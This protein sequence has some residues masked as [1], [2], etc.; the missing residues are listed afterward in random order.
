MPAEGPLRHRL[1]P[2]DRLIETLG[3]M[4]GA[5]A[6][7]A[8]LHLDRLQR[9]ADTL[10]F[11]FARMGAVGAL[12]RLAHGRRPLRVRLTLGRGGDLETTQAPFQPMPEGTVWRLA[13]ASARLSSTDGLLAHKTTKRD[14]YVAARAEFGPDEAD[15]VLLLNERGELC[16]GTITNVFADMGDGLL[17]T[18]PLGCG[19]LPGILRQEL[20]E[21][22]RAV[23]RVLRPEDVA[24]AR[25]LYVGNSLRGL[26]PA[27]MA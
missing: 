10:Q 14:A 27:R 4:P 7:R 19:L 1:A 20:L 12:R 23:E 17:S 16:E 24:G 15:E 6:V 3:Y 2:D 26:I 9:S 13:I 22:G 5:G 18:P 21:T 25:A 8:E 11:A